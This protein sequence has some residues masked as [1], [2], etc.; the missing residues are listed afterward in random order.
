[1]SAMTAST[2]LAIMVEKSIKRLVAKDQRYGEWQRWCFQ[3]SHVQ[4]RNGVMSQIVK[5][6]NIKIQPLDDPLGSFTCYSR[7]PL[8]SRQFVYT[9]NRVKAEIKPTCCCSFSHRKT[10][11]GEVVVMITRPE[12]A[13]EIITKIKE[14]LK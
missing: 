1:M 11:E 9:E 7:C 8:C 13:T 2:L 5:F 6:L 4:G 3:Q 12:S 10:D 14:G